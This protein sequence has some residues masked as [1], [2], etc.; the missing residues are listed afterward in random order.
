V[1]NTLSMQ[2][3]YENFLVCLFKDEDVSTN[4]MKYQWWI[5]AIS[6]IY[7]QTYQYVI[8][9]NATCIKSDLLSKTESNIVW[10]VRDYCKYLTNTN[11]DLNGFST[12]K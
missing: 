11:H 7:K 9:L 12:K 8:I 3:I 4:S 1:Q 2:L 10:Q 6:K 5:D